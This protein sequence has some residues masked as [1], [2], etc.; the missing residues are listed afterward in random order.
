MILS[1]LVFVDLGSIDCSLDLV[2]GYEKY[3]SQ[4]EIRLNI[5]IG[6]ILFSTLGIERSNKDCQLGGETK[7]SL[8]LFAS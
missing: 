8:A 3:S 2:S 5:L 7:R 4:L 6:L 1:R